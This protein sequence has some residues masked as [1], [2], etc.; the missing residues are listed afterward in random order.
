MNCE[1]EYLRHCAC[2]RAA[3]LDEAKV[4]AIEPLIKAHGAGV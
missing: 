2:V 1:F 3:M 4:A